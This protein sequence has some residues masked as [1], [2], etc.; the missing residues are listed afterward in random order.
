MARTPTWPPVTSLQIRRVIDAFQRRAKTIKQSLTGWTCSYD[1]SDG[2]RLDLDF[3]TLARTSIRLTL[4][5]DGPMWFRACRPGARRHGGWAFVW[6]FH[7]DWS[8]S[9]A[10]QIV[11]MFEASLYYCDTPSPESEQDLMRVWS[12][13]SPRIDA[14]VH[15]HS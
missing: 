9:S 6:A 8:N 11:E 12:T 3:E 7:A 4:W 1:I 15:R 5:G 2:E 14:D 10:E 13:T